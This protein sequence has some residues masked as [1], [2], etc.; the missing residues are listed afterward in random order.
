MEVKLTKRWKS[1]PAGTVLTSVTKRIK[2][3]LE[4]LGVIEVEKKARKKP[5]RHKMVESAPESKKR[6]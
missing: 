2:G 4:E 3:M 6:K 5:T 1:H